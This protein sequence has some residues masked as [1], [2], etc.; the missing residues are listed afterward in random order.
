MFNRKS[1]LAHTLIAACA[2][3]ST[4]AGL[5][6]ASTAA[7]ATASMSSSNTAPT[8]DRLSDTFSGPVGSKS[9]AAA[10]IEGMRAGNDVRMADVTVSGT[11]KSMGYGNV[12][13]ALSLARADAG[14]AATTKGFLSSL[15]KVMDMR[16]GGMGW[17]QISKDLGFKLGEVVSTS[18]TANASSKGSNSAKPDKSTGLVDAGKG[19][20][21]GQSTAGGQGVGGKGNG[22]AGEDGNSGGGNSGGG[23]SG[24]GNGG[25]G[26]KK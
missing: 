25:G 4:F 6:Q 16:A 13:I 12:N 3:I 1:R 11:G 9:N 17:G 26:G 14:A 20:R 23:N 7:A 24:G 18:K 2:F 15:D 5:V 21:Q 8:A 10:L 19:N 22:K